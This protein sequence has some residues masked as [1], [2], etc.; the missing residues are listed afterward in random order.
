MASLGANVFTFEPG[1]ATS[2][3]KLV[4]Y[5][6]SQFRTTGQKWWE[7]KVGT[8]DA[9]TF[10][11]STLVNGEIFDA[12][13][14]LKF[15]TTG[16]LGIP[17]SLTIAG[18]IIAGPSTP[19]TSAAGEVRAQ[20]FVTP[21]GGYLALNTDYIGGT[22]WTY[23][24][25][26]GFAAL[27]QLTGTGYID[28]VSAAASTGA[29][30][31]LAGLVVGVNVTPLGVG[32][33]AQGGGMGTP[34]PPRY[35]NGASGSAYSI[36]MNGAGVQ[37][38]CLGNANTALKFAFGY[39]PS[40]Y[41]DFGPT[42]AT[43]QLLSTPGTGSI[44]VRH[45]RTTNSLDTALRINPTGLIQFG[46]NANSIPGALSSTYKFYGTLNG[47]LDGNYVQT[48]G[49]NPGSNITSI[50][51]VDGQV[52]RLL[53]IGAGAITLPATV[54]LSIGS[55]GNWGTVGTIVNLIALGGVVYATIVPF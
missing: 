3:V 55:A 22:G 50:T 6:T 7:V 26:A 24:S 18:A 45:V 17:G 40:I 53:V 8:D 25:A 38:A 46:N 54:K 30:A 36:D 11:P 10:S 2:P 31:A 27:R 32:I 37:V 44:I 28:Y 19:V 1:Q 5:G 41:V 35:I 49:L 9:L 47:G 23:I 34:N 33:S 12:T 39:D 20:A 42:D 13:K 4:H 14:A 29:G 21:N 51:M 15:G 48:L 16:S 52:S 43:G